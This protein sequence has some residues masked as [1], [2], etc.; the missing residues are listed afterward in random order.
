MNLMNGVKGLVDKINRAKQ[1]NNRELFLMYIINHLV[2]GK[3]DE[4]RVLKSLVIT[5]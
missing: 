5:Q 1:K 3:F 2:D 4:H